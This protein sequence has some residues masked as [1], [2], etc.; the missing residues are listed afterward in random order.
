MKQQKEIKQEP[1]QTVRDPEDGQLKTSLPNPYEKKEPVE[2]K[3]E[4]VDNA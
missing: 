4:E 2:K 3:K 1:I